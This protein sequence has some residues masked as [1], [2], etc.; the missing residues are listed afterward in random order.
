MPQD[1]CHHLTKKNPEVSQ[2]GSNGQQDASEWL[3]FLFE[4]LHSE[5]NL[6]CNVM[7]GPS[8]SQTGPAL[9]AAL[10]FWQE[11]CKFNESIIDKYFRGIEATITTCRVCRNVST[12]MEQTLIFNLVLNGSDSTLTEHLD[13]A[14]RAED[15]SG[16]QCDKCERL[17]P[18]SKMTR[19]A[20]LPEV[21]V[22][23]LVRYDFKDRGMTKNTTRV[24]F[25][26]D[27]QSFESVFLD[28][29]Q[30]GLRAGQ[31]LPED[32]NGFGQEFRYRCFGVVMHSG[33]SPY[34]GH[35]YSYLRDLRGGG[36]ESTWWRCN[37]AKVNEMDS[38]FNVMEAC[39]KDARRAPGAE[40]FLLFFK[41]KM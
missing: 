27:S 14:T 38:G 18:A 7:G 25:D 26:V 21:L 2:F 28:P 30:R 33:E 24:T 39:K 37:D 15:V 22:V 17:Q 8:S 32:D 35:Y 13:G 16:Y 12:R 36:R 40:P 6:K 31:A 34:H 1:Y 3:M 9:Q 41:R 5:T 10:D 19:F 20:R 4:Q 11:H 23:M 29:D